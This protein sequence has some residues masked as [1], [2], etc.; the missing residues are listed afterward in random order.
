[1]KAL[2]SVDEHFF[3]LYGDSYL[4]CDYA[5]VQ[6]SFEAQKKLCLMTVLQNEGLWDSSNIE[7]AQ[8]KIMTY[9]KINKTA[10]MKHIDYGLGVFSKEAFQGFPEDVPL[11]LATVYQRALANHALAAFEVQTRFYEIGS[12]SGLKELSD[13]LT[14]QSE[15]KV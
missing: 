5:A 2:P 13:Y 15:E 4:Q 14:C 12:F 6:R 1:M 8:G 10:R 9:D 11:D 7:Y 3:V